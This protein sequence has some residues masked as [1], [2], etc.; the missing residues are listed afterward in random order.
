M[1]LKITITGPKVHDVG[2]RYHL[3]GLA[4]SSKLKGFDAENQIADG[5]QQVEVLVEGGEVAVNKF[6]DIIKT[7]KPPGAEVSD[8]SFSPYQEAVMKLAD[9]SGWC[10]NIQ[11]NKGI[12]AILGIAQILN[13]NIEVLKRRDGRQED[14]AKTNT[15]ILENNTQILSEIKGLREDQPNPA[16]RQLQLDMA[17]VKARLNI[18]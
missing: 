2:Y 4:R 14:I 1:K 11:L 5:P 9:Y 8:I 17:A 15:Q 10:T 16:I 12:Q 13:E 7:A 18:P 3:M 6:T